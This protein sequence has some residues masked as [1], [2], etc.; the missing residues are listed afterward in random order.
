MAAGAVV[1]AAAHIPVMEPFVVSARMGTRN[2]QT[3]AAILVQLT[4]VRVAA[5]AVALAVAHIPVV[6]PFAGVARIRLIHARL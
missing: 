1:Q 3:T 4:H 5:G 6:E 2:V